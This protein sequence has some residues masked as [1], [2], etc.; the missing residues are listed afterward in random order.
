MMIT[1]SLSY[2][3]SVVLSELMSKKMAI[4]GSLVEMRKMGIMIMVMIVMMIRMMML[5]TVFIISIKI[6]YLFSHEDEKLSSDD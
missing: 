2:G 4:S 5:I 6:I 3:V 1:F